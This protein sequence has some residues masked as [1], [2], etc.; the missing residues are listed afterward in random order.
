MQTPQEEQTENNDDY[1]DLTEEKPM[2]SDLLFDIEVDSLVG[3]DT[4]DVFDW[5]LI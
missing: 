1:I 2:A 4:K 3:F 5:S